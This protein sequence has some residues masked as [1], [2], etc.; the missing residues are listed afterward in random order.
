MS[1]GREILILSRPGFSFCLFVRGGGGGGGGRGVMMSYDVLIKSLF[2]NSG[3]LRY[4]I[5]E[6]LF[7]PKLQGSA[8]T[9]QRMIKTNKQTLTWER[10]FSG[11]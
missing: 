6:F 9:K 10:C 8:E 1:I 4:A 3:H 2:L 5:F 11:H 7:S